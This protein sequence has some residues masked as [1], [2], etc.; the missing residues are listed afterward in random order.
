MPWCLHML[1]GTEEVGRGVGSRKLVS[2][3]PGYCLQPRVGAAFPPLE[4]AWVNSGVFR[5]CINEAVHATLKISVVGKKGRWPS[6]G[7]AEA[8]RW[9]M[10][11]RGSCQEVVSLSWFLRWAGI[12]QPALRKHLGYIC[13]A[14]LWQLHWKAWINGSQQCFQAGDCLVKKE[15]LRCICLPRCY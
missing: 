7:I 2:A 14:L 12:N 3:Q 4:G 6:G 8:R 15:N 5:V 10:L 13:I 9:E 11:S 1:A